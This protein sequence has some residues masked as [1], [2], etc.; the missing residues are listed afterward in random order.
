MALPELNKTTTKIPMYGQHQHSSG[1][2]LLKLN[3]FLEIHAPP[4]KKKF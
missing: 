4:P 3:L 2:Q 1:T